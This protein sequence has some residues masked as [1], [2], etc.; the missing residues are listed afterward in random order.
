MP[1]FR[2]SPDV[3]GCH[4]EPG[5]VAG[6]FVLSYCHPRF[7]SR[8]NSCNTNHL[9]PIRGLL[10]VH[11]DRMRF[12]PPKRARTS[13]EE[14]EPPWRR[15]L[16]E[17]T[18]SD[19]RIG[20]YQQRSRCGHKGAKYRQPRGSIYG[21]AG[22]ETGRCVLDNRPPRRK[23]HRG[24]PWAD[25]ETPLFW[26]RAAVATVDRR[27]LASGQRL[28]SASTFRRVRAFASETVRP[29]PPVSTTPKS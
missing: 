22:P 16:D 25:F 14:S 24:E 2:R 19:G 27:L 11:P 10:L 3:S 5:L 8:P 23:Q 7:A 9:T 28:R 6:T 26:L 29:A 18:L 15:A 17:K 20:C 4:L 1:L 13:S 12:R 21:A